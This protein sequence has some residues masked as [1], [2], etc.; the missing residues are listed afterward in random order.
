[1]APKRCETSARTTLASVH[2]TNMPRLAV[3]IHD[4]TGPY[5]LLVH[6][7]LAS[8]AAWMP[9]LP[10]LAR[11][12]RPVVVELWGHGRSPTPEDTRH[13]HPDAY[14]EQLDGIRAELGADRWFICGLSLGAAL[15]IRYALDR[16]DR[17]IGHVF[18]N[19]SSAFGDADWIENLRPVLAADADRMV[20]QGRRALENHPLN[21][22]RGRRLPPEVRER[23]VADCARHDPVGVARTLLHTVPASPVRDRIHANERPALLVAGRFE[24]AFA[25]HRAHAEVT[26]PKLRVVDA[27]AGHA[28]NLEAG[29]TFDEAVAAF[30]RDHS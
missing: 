17:V 3:K 29:Q 14:V 23:L 27:D 8:R 9:N 19:S 18:T 24:S 26:M 2:V 16:P 21:P 10:A 1:M 30:V 13:Y 22:S 20:A 25:D 5:L 12:A 11:V 15:T 6:G 28:V 4:G 7:L